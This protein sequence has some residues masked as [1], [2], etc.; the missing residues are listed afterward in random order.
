MD[1]IIAYYFN[2][3]NKKFRRHEVQKTKCTKLTLTAQV[4]EEQPRLSR[5]CQKE[6]LC[7][8]VC[9]VC[10]HMRS[11]DQDLK[12]V[13]MSATLDAGKFQAYFDN[14]P[15]MNVPGRWAAVFHCI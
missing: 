9:L 3:R 14:A 10:H 7:S 13:I 1:L 5:V 11:F 8:A 12:L 2:I 6:E 15:L 4:F